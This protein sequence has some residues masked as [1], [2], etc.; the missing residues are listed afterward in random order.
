MP[1]SQTELKK[2]RSIL[3]KKG[4]QQSGLFLAEGVR[5]LEEALHHR[6]LPRR[7]YYA[8]SLMSARAERLTKRLQKAEVET[9]SLSAR[10]LRS[11]ADTETPRGLVGLF[12][13]PNTELGKLYRT[14][15]RRLVLCE[16]I[17][18]PGNLG[19]L[20]RSA[21]AFGFQLMLLTGNSAE[22]FAPKVV[23]ASAGA[24]FGL[25]LSE[26]SRHQA[27]ALATREKVMLIAADVRGRPDLLRIRRDWCRRK[28]MLAI[29]SEATGLS[30]GILDACHIRVRI[31]QAGSVQ[32]LNAAVAG[33]ILMKQ[34][35]DFAHRG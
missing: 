26:V 23:R 22:P 1:L 35:Y 9:I 12:V 16:N 32:S 3:T 4:R 14:G 34:I 7:L 33:S 30:S 20:V 29:G 25:P 11:I 17:S 15:Y 10:E 8:S 18:D 19:T 2:T 31:E 5:L 21:L 28:I 24:V 6:F 27:R 13:Q